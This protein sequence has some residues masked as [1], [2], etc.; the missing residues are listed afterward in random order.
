MRPGG[1][2][3]GNNKDRRARK[4]WLL[5]HFDTDLGPDQVRCHLGISDRCEGLLDYDS[6]TADR[7]EMG[8]SYRRENLRPSCY[9]CQRR[10]GGLANADLMS[11][12]IGAFRDARDAWADRFEAATGR[13]YVPGIIEEERRK[14]RRGGR[15]EVT[16]FVDQDPPPLFADWLSEWH[17]SRRE[18]EAS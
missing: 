18:S 6:V 16:D 15:R 14:E 11:G 9:T 3:R 8:G 12:L 17:A 7:I 1:E 5:S 4:L 13:T 2:R 10:Q